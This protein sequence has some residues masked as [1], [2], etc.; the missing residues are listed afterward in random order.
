MVNIIKSGDKNSLE[1][2]LRIFRDFRNK[3]QPFIVDSNEVTIADLG[4]GYRQVLTDIMDEL[5]SEK[6]P[7]LKKS[8]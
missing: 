8:A 4:G 6:V 5:K 7:L 1:E 3:A 2:C